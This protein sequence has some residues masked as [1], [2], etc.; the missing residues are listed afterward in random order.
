MTCPYH[1]SLPFLIFIL[2]RSILTVL[3]MYSFPI[4]SFL[5]TPI[6][7]LNIFISATSISSTRFFAIATVSSPHNSAGLTTELDT[8]PFTITNNLLSQITP[9][10]SLHPLHPA[11]TL[12]FTSLS[13]P[14]LSCTVDPKYSNSPTP[15]TPASSIPTALLSSPPSTHRH[16][17]LDYPPSSPSPQCTPPGFQSLLHP[18]LGPPQTPTLS[19]N[20]LLGGSLLTSSINLSIITENRNRLNADPWCSPTLTLKLFVVSTAHL[21]TVSLTPYIS[22]T[23]R[24]YFS[25]IPDF[26]IQYH[27]SFRGTLQQAISR[28]TNTQCSSPRP[29]PHPSIN[30]LKANMASVVLFPGINPHYFLLISTPSPNLASIVLFHTFT[31]WLTSC[32]PL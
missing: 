29:S 22:C 11:C 3:L 16:S 12:L 20:S 19:A 31:A 6:A 26:F 10:T 2:N 21:T 15:G 14:P 17:V 30:I 25:T 5:V 8:L 18:L 32:I 27:S 4:F 13:Q 7:N 9:D 24:T 28:S 1:L 23:S